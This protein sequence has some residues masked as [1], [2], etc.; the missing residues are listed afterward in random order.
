VFALGWVSLCNDAASEMI[1]PLLPAFLVGLGASKLDLGLLQGISDLV[2]A[3]LKLASGWIS[4]RQRRRKP[5][6]VLGYG[7]SCSLRPLLALVGSPWHATVVRTADR[8]GKGIRTAPR[9][10]L[11]AD[12]VTAADRGAAYGV[13]RSMDHTGALLG[14][15]AAAGLVALGWQERSIFAL[16]AIP[17]AVVLIVL[18]AFVREPERVEPAANAATPANGGNRAAGELRPLLPFLA[19]VVCSAFG[20]GLDLFLLSRAG[21]LGVTGVALPLLYALLHVVRASLAAPLGAWS[22]R[23][24][25]RKVIAIG[26]S[27]HAFVLFGFGLVDTAAWLWPLFALHGLHA[28][29]TE[30]AE[31]GYVADLTGAGRRG[32]V[33]GVYHAVQGLAAFAAPVTMGFVWKDH[34]A[35]AAFGVAAVAQVIA[36]LLLVAIVPSSRGRRD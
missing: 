33:F 27:I 7:L 12:A 25:R 24:G 35:L 20:T 17:G 3:A 19:V 15:L 28:A 36:V 34:G 23:L 21:D 2:L 8:V 6:I 1:V 22:D 32:T 9:D 11:L 4:D 13:Q 10:A 26:L 29:F 18:I 30:G 16:A 14:S 5:W 31:R